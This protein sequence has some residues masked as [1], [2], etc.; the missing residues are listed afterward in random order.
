MKIV[1][2]LANSNILMDFKS[3]KD[4]EKY[5]GITQFIFP[6]RQKNV[7]CQNVTNTI[8]TSCSTSFDSGNP[9]ICRI[10]AINSIVNCNY[11]TMC[12]VI[13]ILYDSS[14]YIGLITSTYHKTKVNLII[15]YP[16]FYVILWGIP[17]K[18]YV[19]LETQIW[20][21]SILTVKYAIKTWKEN[22]VFT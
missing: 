10:S 21:I 20:S 9:P 13:L 6:N 1:W 22:W 17:F 7:L 15:S 18:I 14:I 16:W 5:I 2:P 4:H 11:C 8:D 3:T 19:K 12:V